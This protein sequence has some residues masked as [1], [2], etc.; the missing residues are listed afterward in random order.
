MNGTDFSFHGHDAAHDIEKE[1]AHINTIIDPESIQT[2]VYVGCCCG[3]EAGLLSNVYQHAEVHAIEAVQ[4]TYDKYL[5]EKRSC[6]TPRVK[7][8]CLAISNVNGTAK[9]NMAKMNT[10][11]S[12]LDP[13]DWDAVSTRTVQCQTLQKFCSLNGLKPDMIVLDVEGIPGR[14]LVGAGPEILS[15][16]KVVFAE[17]EPHD[18][19][20]FAD[21]DTDGFVDRLLYTFGMKRELCSVPE[22]PVRQLNSVWVRRP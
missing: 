1:A 4:E 6:C 19:K 21:G 7:T 20:V 17:T 13:M 12:L 15:T 10:Q 22:P 3:Y 8:H 5:L 14:V 2:I 11:H 9:L 16:V 18:A